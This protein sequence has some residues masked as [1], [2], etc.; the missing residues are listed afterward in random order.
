MH[1]VYS[2]TLVSRLLLLLLPVAVCA[3]DPKLN[4]EFRVKTFGGA[5]SQNTPDAQRSTQTGSEW[6]PSLM[7]PPIA[8]AAAVCVPVSLLAVTLITLLLWSELALYLQVDTVNHLYVDVSRGEKMKINFDVTFPRIP[9]S[10][11]NPM[12]RRA[13]HS[14][15]SRSDVSSSIS[16]LC[17]ICLCCAQC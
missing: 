5:I 12:R 16:A 7:M 2:E 10:S 14:S 8:A 15:A 4:E 17:A 1:V 3:S 9:C 11:T 13:A 6:T